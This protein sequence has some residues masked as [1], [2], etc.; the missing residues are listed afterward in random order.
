MGTAWKV[1][2]MHAPVGLIARI[3]GLSKEK[4]MVRALKHI[5]QMRNVKNAVQTW[6]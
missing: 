1:C 2:C 4:V 3:P 5:R 6:Y